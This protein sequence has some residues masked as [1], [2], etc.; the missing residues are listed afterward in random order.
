MQQ[1]KFSK[2]KYFFSGRLLISNYYITVMN[3]P[4]TILGCEAKEYAHKIKEKHKNE[5]LIALN[6][7]LVCR[8]L[9][10]RFSLFFFLRF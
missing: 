8:S 7:M 4:V 9:G 5:I 10:E 2:I 1:N 6:I 3:A